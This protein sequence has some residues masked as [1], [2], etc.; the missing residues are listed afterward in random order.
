MKSSL[1]GIRGGLAYL[2]ARPKRR[3][4]PDLGRTS[5]F[6]FSFGGI[7]TANLANR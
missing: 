7:I 5:Y 1:S 3:V 6:G 2:H 4:Q